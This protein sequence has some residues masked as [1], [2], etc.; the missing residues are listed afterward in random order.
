[1]YR[2]GIQKFPTC[3]SLK[4]QYAYFLME[5]MNKKSEAISELNQ[6]TALNAP[7]DEQFLIYRYQKISEDY[8]DGSSGDGH[9]GSAGMDIVAKF[10]YESSLRQCTQHI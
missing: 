8:G 5:R 7:F 2:L 1:M 10:A 6:A 4:I 9:G 3:T